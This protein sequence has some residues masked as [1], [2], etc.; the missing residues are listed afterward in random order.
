MQTYPA[1]AT[2]LANLG[3]IESEGDVASGKNEILSL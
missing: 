3:Q 2:L 1:L